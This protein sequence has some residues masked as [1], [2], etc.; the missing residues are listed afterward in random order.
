ML[1]G[2]FMIFDSQGCDANVC[3]MLLTMCIKC[4][5]VE[6]KAGLLFCVPIF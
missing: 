2:L 6:R 4:F 5:C 1:P 3:E